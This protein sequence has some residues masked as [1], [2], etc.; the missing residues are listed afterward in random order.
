MSASSR[1]GY[2]GERPLEVLLT[3]R[4]RHVWRPRAGAPHDTGDLHGVPLVISAKNHARL[5][6]AGWVS[7]VEAMAVAA[8]LRSGVVWHKKKGKGNPLDWYV[9]TSGRLFLPLLDL[10]YEH[11]E[12]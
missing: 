11:W 1:K 9:T 2:A 6:L 4:G 8:G 3:E 5:D 12:F 7:D 10:A